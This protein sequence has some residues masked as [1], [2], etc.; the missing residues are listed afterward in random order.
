MKKIIKIAIHAKHVGVQFLSFPTKSYN[1][2][3]YPRTKKLG[4][5]FDE[6][7]KVNP[8]EPKGMGMALDRLY[9]RKHSCPCLL[10]HGNV[11]GDLQLCLLSPFS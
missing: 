9:D 4:P 8:N 7:R 3:I 1:Q 2:Y 10:A 6:H 5:D 11:E